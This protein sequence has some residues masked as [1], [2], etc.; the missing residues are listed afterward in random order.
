VW[1]LRS[2]I[3]LVGVAALVWLGTKNAGTKITFHLFTRTYIDVEL[4][5]VMVITFIAG[6]LVWA[7]GSW[8]REAQLRLGLLKSRREIRKLKDE[9]SDL[10]NLPLEEES[11]PEIAD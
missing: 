3:L 7:I 5:L 6:M 8:I 11:E 1:I 9:I 2:I 10:R 4:N